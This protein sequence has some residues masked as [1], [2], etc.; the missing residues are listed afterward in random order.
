MRTV[1]KT[2]AEAIQAL[3][4][5]ISYMPVQN[6]TDAI[7]SQCGEGAKGRLV[8]CG[9]GKSGLIG[10]KIAA[11]FASTGTPSYFLHPAEARHGDLGMVTEDDVVL[12]LSHSGRSEELTAVLQ[13]LK[14]IGPPMIAICGDESSP[15]A[16]HSD[17]VLNIGKQIEACPLGLAPTTS[18]AVILALGDALALAVQ[19]KRNF[20]PAQYARFHPGGE[21][22][23][24]LMTCAE[25]MRP[26]EHVAIVQQETAVRDAIR[27][28]T[29][30]RTGCAIIAD[31]E[32][33]LI[34]ILTDGDLR[35]ALNEN[36]ANLLDEP[37]LEIATQPG[38][39]VNES[40]LLAVAQRIAAQFHIDEMPVI[41]SEMKV[42]GLID[43]QD[44]MQRGY[45]R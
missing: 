5:R 7:L 38:Q 31:Q 36:P 10:R 18:T 23:R 2:E 37:V 9:I 14:R 39:S 13:P 27:A 25:A 22:G 19:E 26:I 32:N 42:L 43:L 11:T 45:T 1:L 34:G 28:I 33:K 16:K 12:L 3:A 44:L 30:K 15:L 40:E 29:A 41:N 20:T 8:I 4:D 24:S 21:L 35:R 6:A 17:I